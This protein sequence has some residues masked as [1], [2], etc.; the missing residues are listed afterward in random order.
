[1]KNAKGKGYA[2]KIPN[3]GSAVVK[4][5]LQKQQRGSATVKVGNDL[6]N[7]SK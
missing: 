2:G 7:G 5:P 4:A 3:S 6:R 1:M